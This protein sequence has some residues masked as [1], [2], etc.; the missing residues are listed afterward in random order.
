MQ[1]VRQ[2]FGVIV[3]S[4]QEIALMRAAGRVV[5]AI[6]ESLAKAVRPGV[7]TGEL[8]Q[9]AAEE[10]ERWEAQASFK[11]YRGFPASICT[12]INE[13]VVHGI[14]GDRT[15]REGDIVSLDFGAKL[16][17]FHA[18]AAVT[19]GAGRIARE[20]QSM[21]DVTRVALEEGI[22]A[23]GVGGRIGDISAAIQSYVEGRGFSVVREYVGHGIGRSL[24][25]D[26]QIPNF[27]NPGDG[28]V[29][30][31]GMTLALEPMVNAGTWRTRV[32]ENGWTVVTVDGR[33]SAHFEHTIAITDSGPEIL[34]VL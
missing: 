22:S 10:V 15:L 17:G 4:P 26:P 29:L 25:E 8:D 3:K 7:T 2:D 21:I 19:L 16:N 20:A 33:L 14:P 11:N 24:H 31:R 27:G 32:A 18:D 30:Q 1:L 12:S 6:L 34:T 13:E 5:A 23:A 9:V 28:L